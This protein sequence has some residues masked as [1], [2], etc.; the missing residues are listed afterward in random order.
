MEAPFSE[1]AF[2]REI[3][4]AI[5]HHLL[6][7]SMTLALRNAADVQLV[8]RA[9]TLDEA[10]M[11]VHFGGPLRALLSPFRRTVARP[12]LDVLILV[13]ATCLAELLAASLGQPRAINAMARQGC[14]V[15]PSDSI[16]RRFVGLSV[17]IATRKSALDA[18]RIPPEEDLPD[19]VLV[20][21]SLAEGRPDGG[22]ACFAA[23]RRRD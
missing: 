13:M 7:P 2:L 4:R 22:A 5:I 11:V 14:A 20:M 17:Q 21:A 6:N 23:A 12:S 9:L 18:L 19:H 10:V 8:L 15:L 16:A 3:N 1:L